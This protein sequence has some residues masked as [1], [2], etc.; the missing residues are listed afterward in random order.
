MRRPKISII[1][2]SFNQG[3]YIEKT[4][5]SV[6]N[7]T[8]DNVE[9]IIMDGGSTDETVE[10]IKKYSDKIDFWVSEKDDGQSDAI[11]RGFEK[12]TGDIITW[13]NSDDYYYDDKALEAIADAYMNS[14]GYE[15]FVGN[16]I[17]V[18]INGK[19]IMRRENPADAVINTENILKDKVHAHQ[20]TVFFTRD[21]YFRCGGLDK[22][23]HFSMDIDLMLRMSTQANFKAVDKL[24]AVFLYHDEAKCVAEKNIPDWYAERMIVRSRYDFEMG[25]KMIRDYVA[26]V[27]RLNAIPAYKVLRKIYWAIKGKK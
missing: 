13:L 25:K 27:Q 14:E 26:V 12:S 18:D 21:L 20:P 8:Y 9:Y 3:K 6:I 17:G 15:V 7:Q 5:L 2:P 23:L 24:V 22:R 4:I 19:E 11:H 10:I 1:T 16:E